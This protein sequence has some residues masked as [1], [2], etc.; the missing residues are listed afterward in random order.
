MPQTLGSLD[1][2]RLQTK[3]YEAMLATPVGALSKRDLE[4]LAL[5]ELNATDTD[6]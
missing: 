4:I 1:F 6:E 3:L 2:I 5:L